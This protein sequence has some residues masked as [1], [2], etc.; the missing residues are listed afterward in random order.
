MIQNKFLDQSIQK[1]FMP[2]TPGCIE[3]HL[4][5]MSVLSEARKKHKTLAVCWLDLKS[6][7]GSVH[8]SLI[9]YSL[10]HYHA[11]PKF[12]NMIRFFYQ[13]LSASAITPEWSTAQ[14]PLNIG[15][16]QGG[17]LSVMIFNTVINT[18]VDSADQT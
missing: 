16:F 7:Y 1:D 3:N 6:A 18:L 9:E 12:Y 17:P 14:I 13:E 11:P 15:V 10:K 8:H 4:K 2:S 5:L